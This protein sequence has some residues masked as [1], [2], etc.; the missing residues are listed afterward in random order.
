MQVHVGSHTHESAYE[1]VGALC[2][3]AAMASGDRDGFY[4]GD[5]AMNEADGPVNSKRKVYSV[6]ERRGIKNRMYHM[7]D[8]LDMFRRQKEML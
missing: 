7:F 3:K 2:C 8:L 6:S 5:D 1:K 4:M